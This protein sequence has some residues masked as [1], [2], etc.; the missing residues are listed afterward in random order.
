[1]AVRQEQTAHATGVKLPL[2]LN[3]LSGSSEQALKMLQDDERVT[4]HCLDPN[5][6]T[7]VIKDQVAAGTGRIIVCGGD[8]TLALAANVV[9]GSKTEMAV[10]PGGTLN[11][12]VQNHGIPNDFSAA[13]DLAIT[14]QAQ[15]IGTGYVNDRIFLN[16]SSVGAYTLFVRSRDSLERK[17]SY[18]TASIVAGLR[19]LIRF[20]SARISLNDKQ[21]RSPLVFIG[22]FER[23]LQFPFLGQRKAAGQDGLHVIAMNTQSRWNSLLI[24]CKA[25][26]LG[27]DPLAKDQEVE[28]AVLENMELNFHSSK[29]KVT[30]AL[31]GELVKLSAPLQYRFVSDGLKV[32]IPG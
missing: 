5:D 23:D 20:R 11:H 8:G 25:M 30:V 13:L 2:F 17:M 27:N 28:N 22:V 7:A 6:M 15:S 31:D 9:A 14:G 29:A 26:L 16:T 1:M 10:L 4:V 18:S 32:V 19:R 24:A 3:K 12:F 21:L